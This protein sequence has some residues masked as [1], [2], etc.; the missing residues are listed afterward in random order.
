MAN[1]IAMVTVKNTEHTFL[2]LYLG[3]YYTILYKIYENKSEAKGF[4]PDGISTKNWGLN[5]RLLTSKP[6]FF[7]TILSMADSFFPPLKP[8]YPVSPSNITAVSP[9]CRQPTPIHSI[10]PIILYDEECPC[11]KFWAKRMSLKWVSDLWRS[12]KGIFM[13]LT[14][15]RAR[16]MSKGNEISVSKRH[17]CLFTITKIWSQSNIQTWISEECVA[18]VYTW[19]TVWVF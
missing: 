8:N 7:R 12:L 16:Y 9:W 3:E 5:P 13:N 6:P 18:C 11:K 10:L 2:H 19:N 15:P 14:A 4:G 17:S 1:V